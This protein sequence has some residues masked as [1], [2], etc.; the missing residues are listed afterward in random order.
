MS[1][2]GSRAAADPFDGHERADQEDQ[3]GRNVQ[4][5]RADHR[6]QLAKQDRQV[7]R[8]E[9]EIGIG[10]DQFADVPAKRAGIEHFPP[11]IER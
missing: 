3:V 7:D 4:V 8:V 5:V 9:R 2:C 11:D 10:G 1:K 6:H